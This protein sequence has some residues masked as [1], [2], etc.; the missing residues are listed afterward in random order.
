MDIDK[1]SHSN[2]LH[3]KIVKSLNLVGLCRYDSLCKAYI[4]EQS[5]SLVNCLHILIFL[6]HFACYTI[7]PD[8]HQ[9]HGINTYEIMKSHNIT[10]CN[11]KIGNMVQLPPAEPPEANVIDTF[12]RLTTI[13]SNTN[14]DQTSKII[15]GDFLQIAYL[16]LTTD[17]VFFYTNKAS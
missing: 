16:L 10:I 4:F 8:T 6:K 14:V 2:T 17:Q 7:I 9:W 5:K 3:N 1:L 11:D 15:Y 13:Y 12:A